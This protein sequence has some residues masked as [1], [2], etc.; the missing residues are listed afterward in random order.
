MQNKCQRSGWRG[1][2]L[3]ADVISIF[4]NQAPRPA[5]LIRV[6]ACLISWYFIEN[7]SRGMRLFMLA[8]REECG[9]ERS[10]IRRFFLETF[11]VAVPMGLTR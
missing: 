1:I 7:S 5:F 4:A 8:K 11:L 9:E 3:K 10:K 2:T 6:I